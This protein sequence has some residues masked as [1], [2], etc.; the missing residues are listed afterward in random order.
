M[1]KKRL[2]TGPQAARL[3]HI[4]FMDQ[5]RDGHDVEAQVMA[6]PFTFGE[7][8]VYYVVEKGGEERLICDGHIQRV[9]RS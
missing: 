1:K 2:Y 8:E 9:I 5:A 7:W 4:V 3:D 6:G